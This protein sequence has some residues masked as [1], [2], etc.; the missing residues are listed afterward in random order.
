[1][2][3]RLTLWCA[4]LVLSVAI[5][6]SAQAGVYQPGARPPYDAGILIEAETGTVLFS[7]N[8]RLQ[9]SPAS[10]LKLLLELVVMEQIGQGKLAL[11]DSVRVSKEASRVGGSQVYLKEGE[12]FPL[13]DLMAAVVIASG[14]DA[15]L[16]VAE[17]IAGSQ[18]G[19]VA[20]MNARA[21][22]LG[23]D[24]TH[25]V[26]VH[27]L[28][29][30]PA[31]NRNLTSAHDLAQMA[32]RLVVHPEVLRWSSTQSK[33]FRGGTF[34][35][36]NTNH[37]LGVFAGMDG[38]KT[39]FTARA[40]FCLVATASRDGMRLISVV[41]GAPNSRI[42]SQETARLLSWGFA[43]FSRVQLASAGE[44]LGRV[45]LDDGM[46]PEVGAVTHDSVVAVVRTDQAAHVS[47][48]LD[49]PPR[50]AAPVQAG[51]GLGKLR[52]TLGDSLLA[53]V[54]LIA[55]KTVARMGMWDK[56]MSYF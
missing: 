8:P 19:F 16:A 34:V 5:C 54:E 23:L 47:R 27:G 50:V 11:T 6:G 35:L 15:C 40:K 10:T 30:T 25:C 26:N 49:L 3:A 52:V 17:H 56:L 44:P 51:A 33:P 1:M 53:E 2:R 9:H 48:Q 32:R 13:D 22:D 39:G 41:L 29:D 12:M 20:L 28:D 18:D 43:N 46:E 14:N 21:R 36:G 55:D 31:D 37:L 24:D 38:L 42:R 7:H 45:V 4:F